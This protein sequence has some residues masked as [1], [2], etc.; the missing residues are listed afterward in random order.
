LRYRITMQEDAQEPAAA[1]PFAELRATLGAAFIASLVAAAPAAARLSSAAGIFGPRALVSIAVLGL[2]P[3]LIAIFIVRQ[4]RAALT[5]LCTPAPQAHSFALGLSC[6]LT[7]ALAATFGALLRKTTHHFGLAG[8]TFAVFAAICIVSTYVLSWRL[9]DIASRYSARA[10][11]LLNRIAW[12]LALLFMLLSYVRVL[13]SPLNATWGAILT[14]SAMAVAAVT[15]LS[16]Q[17]FLKSR[18]LVLAGPAPFVVLALLGVRSLW[19]AREV[20]A[21]IAT[22]ASL[23]AGKLPAS[24]P[25]QLASPATNSELVA[26]PKAE[27]APDTNVP[28]PA[29]SGSDA[30]AP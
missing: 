29:L 4:A 12:G 5:A 3:S 24:P 18:L 15:L 8:T 6:A 16:H 21:A 14:D 20:Q 30:K 9:G 1:Q 2:L 28:E 10:L 27:P 22:H 26:T 17:G 7:A 23:Y 11:P 25:S 13:R 19:G